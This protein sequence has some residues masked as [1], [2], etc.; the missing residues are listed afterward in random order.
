MAWHFKPRTRE[1]CLPDGEY[2]AE[3]VSIEPATSKKG[4]SMVVV[5]LA[6]EYEGRRCKVRDWI[7]QGWHKPKV[8][9]I[10]AALGEFEAH[11]AGTFRLREQIMQPIR[12]YVTSEFGDS[13]Y[14]WKN[15]IELYMA[16]GLGMGPDVVQVRTIAEEAELPF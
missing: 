3:I 10:A 7:V 11:A 8:A 16:T 12:V 9:A 14:G 4:N 15:R 5:T 13:K 6:I 1:Q 2:D